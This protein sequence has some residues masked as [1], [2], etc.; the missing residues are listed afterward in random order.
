MLAS[1]RFAT[2][3]LLNFINECDEL[4]E[5]KPQIQPVRIVGQSSEIDQGLSLAKQEAALNDF[6]SG[7]AL[8]FSVIMFEDN[9]LSQ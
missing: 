4:K 3:A 8:E 9:I 5:L 7:I 2:H 1:T 6:K